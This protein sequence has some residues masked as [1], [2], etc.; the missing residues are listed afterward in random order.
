M[1]TPIAD[2]LADYEKKNISRFHMPGHKGKSLLGFEHLDITE[3][4]GADA[5]YEAD[6]I[7]AKS[8]RNA[9]A[10]FGSRR[11]CYSTEGSSQ[12]I[13]AMLYLALTHCTA[14]GRPVVVAARN[15]HKAFVYAAA[16]LDFDVVWLWPEQQKS[17]CGCPVSAEQLE[18]VLAQ[19]GSETDL[20]SDAEQMALIEAE[21]EA[22]LQTSVYCYSGSGARFYHLEPV[23]GNQS[24]RRELT[25][26][27]AML[28]GMGACPDCN[29]PV[30]GFTN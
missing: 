2:F 23:C 20:L 6:G 3:I 22:I 16:M 25:V 8:E 1:K 26:E 4:K 18:E 28:E 27:Q 7:I 30:Y 9:T 10:L 19:G 13:R 15:V 21:Q 12:C 29:P 14:E 11:T 5:L 24:N 17:L